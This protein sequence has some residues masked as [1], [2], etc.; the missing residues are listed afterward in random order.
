M[1]IAITLWYVRVLFFFY[2]FYFFFLFS[3]IRFFQ[4]LGG[5]PE[6]V[7]SEPVW[8]SICFWS[9]FRNHDSIAGLYV[10]KGLHLPLVQLVSKE[11]I[12]IQFLHPF[13]KQVVSCS[14]KSFVD[15][16]FY[17]I[18]YKAADVCKVC[19]LVF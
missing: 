19:E 12:T 9:Q 6:P 10:P 4:K 18:N 7:L 15:P 8:G 16:I 2:F 14:Q 5:I 17:E 1:R 11:E 13:G 3:Q